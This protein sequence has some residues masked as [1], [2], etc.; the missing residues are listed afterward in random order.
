MINQRITETGTQKPGRTTVSLLRNRPKHN[1]GGGMK[2]LKESDRRGR[3]R[4]LS[5]AV[6]F[7]G[8]FFRA[9]AQ[10][11]P[12]WAAGYGDC[13]REGPRGFIPS[14]IGKGTAP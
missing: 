7:A 3:R 10:V 6:V 11:A 9:I 12:S 8:G 4:V 5:L 13:P 2:P 14:G 1:E